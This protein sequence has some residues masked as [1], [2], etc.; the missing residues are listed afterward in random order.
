MVVEQKLAD[1]DDEREHERSWRNHEIHERRQ[2]DVDG[3]VF[4]AAKMSV[5]SLVQILIRALQIEIGDRMLAHEDGDRCE[6][7]QDGLRHR[8]F[9]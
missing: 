9:A 2:C 3:A 6:N 4:D 8:L 5:R 7:N 1:G